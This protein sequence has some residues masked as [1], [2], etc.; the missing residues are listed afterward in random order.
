MS[1]VVFRERG[2]AFVLAVPRPHVTLILGF[3]EC[4]SLLKALLKLLTIVNGFG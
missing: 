1:Q 3:H 4:I 2:A